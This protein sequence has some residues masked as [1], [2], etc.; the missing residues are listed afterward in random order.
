MALSSGIEKKEVTL[1]F[2]IKTKYSGK[3]IVDSKFLKVKKK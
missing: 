2:C 1:I 3:R